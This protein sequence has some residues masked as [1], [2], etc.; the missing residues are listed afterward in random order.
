M[1]YLNGE[2]AGR[3]FCV[4]ES[5]DGLSFRT[6]AL[7]A[8]FTGTEADP[9]VV[10]LADGSWLMAFSRA[11]HTGVGFARSADGLTF[12]PFGTASFG[13]V[14]EL[15][16]AADGRPRLYACARGGVQSYVSPDSG[17]SWTFEGEV[18]TRAATNRAIVCDPSYIASDGLFVFKT[19]DA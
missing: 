9:T 16:L 2:R 3:R 8:S 12:T 13:V 4:A 5:T 18:I 1:F 6:V 11:N 10:K 14:P 17:Q 15:A 7:A 19:T